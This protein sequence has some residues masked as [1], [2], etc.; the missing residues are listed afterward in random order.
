MRRDLAL[1]EIADLLVQRRGRHQLRI[2]SNLCGR[3][4]GQAGESHQKN[5]QQ[6]GCGQEPLS[7]TRGS[8]SKVNDWLAT[9][10]SGQ[11]KSSASTSVFAGVCVLNAS[12]AS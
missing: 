9:F 7:H 6:P 3:I 2:G 4:T 10:I 5:S 8:C 11:N 1:Q 12:T